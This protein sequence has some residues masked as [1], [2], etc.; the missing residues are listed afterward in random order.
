MAAYLYYTDKFYNSDKQGVEKSPY[1]GRIIN[2]Q[3]MKRISNM[4]QDAV[5][6]GAVVTHGGNMNESE[7]YIEPVIV[8]NVSAD[9]IIMQEEIFAPVLPVITFVE[10]H[11]AIKWIR[12]N[13]KPLALYI[14]SGNRKNINFITRQTSAGGTVINDLMTTIVNPALPFGGVNQSGIGKSNGKN[15][16]IEFS[17]ARGGSNKAF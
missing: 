16:F 2:T 15:G 4:L 10:L 6:K 9:M 7:K 14:F 13:P 12:V 17:N 5:Q 11:E 3:H 1:Y 8:E